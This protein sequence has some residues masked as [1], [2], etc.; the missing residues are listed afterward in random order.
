MVREMCGWNKD[1]GRAAV[2][3]DCKSYTVTKRNG[4][5]KVKGGKTTTSG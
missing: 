1:F 5:K 2:V 3:D 4:G